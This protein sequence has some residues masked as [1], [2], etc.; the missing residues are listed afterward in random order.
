[1]AKL[2]RAAELRLKWA[3]YPVFVGFRI[4]W[5]TVG[6]NNVQLDSNDFVNYVNIS[7]SNHYFVNLAAINGMTVSQ[8]GK[9]GLS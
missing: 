7:M 2:V 3:A 5:R 8:F 4:Y 9:F 1:M 6:S